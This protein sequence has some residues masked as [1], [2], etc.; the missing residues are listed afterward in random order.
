MQR[1][2]LHEALQRRA[3]LRCPVGCSRELGS[4]VRLRA[5]GTLIYWT[6]NLN[7]SCTAILIECL[8]A[9]ERLNPRA[10]PAALL[11][12]DEP[13]QRGAC[14]RRGVAKRCLRLPP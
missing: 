13:D 7:H 4:A 14:D 6:R 5:L 1:V 2:A 3:K 10:A 12:R 11:D 9:H 8:F